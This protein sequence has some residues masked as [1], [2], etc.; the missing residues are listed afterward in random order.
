[1]AADRPGEAG[2]PPSGAADSAPP[3]E[4]VGLTQARWLAE[5]VHDLRQP[6]EALALYVELLALEPTRAAELAPRIL[7]AVQA[8]RALLDALHRPG[9]PATLQ[10]VDVQPLLEGLRDQFEP[11]ARRKGLELRLHAPALSV[12]SDALLLRRMLGNLLANA[13]A[14]TQRGGVLLAARRRAGGV[15]LEVRDTGRGVEAEP[16]KRLFEP[17]FQV[18]GAAREG[19]S[20]LGLAIVERLAQSLGHEVE[21]WSRPGRGSVFR[22]LT[23]SS[24]GH[25]CAR[26]AGPG[27]GS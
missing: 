8:A 11:L 25:A 26:G 13:I 18:P 24:T 19:G 14:H 1:M 21:V 20:G 9:Q 4:D 2:R 22:L 7:A 27:C 3:D 16:L 15:V 17:G 5:T 23:G 6:V 10:P 12:Q